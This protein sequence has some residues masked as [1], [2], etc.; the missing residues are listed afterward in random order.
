MEQI[1][2]NERDNV[3]V[4]LEGELKGHKIALSDIKKGENVIKYG[5]PIGH[6]VEDIKAGDHVHTHNIKTNLS[7]VI[8]YT[9]EP[10]LNGVSKSEPRKFMGYRRPN[11]RVGIRNE[12]WIINTVGCVNK[13]SEILA[14]EGNRLY[15]N[16]CDGIFNFVHPFGCSQLGDDQKT[17]QLILKG[18]VEHPNAAGVLVLGLGCENNNIPLFKTVLGETDEKRVKFMSAQDFDD[19]IS[20]GL[21]LIGELAE[22]AASFRRE[23]CDVSE[24]VIGLKC[25]GSDGF[26]GLTA[27][28]LIGRVSDRIIGEG[29]STVLTE[30][31]EMFGAETILMNRCVDTEVF[32]KTVSLI[33]DFKDYFTSHDQVVYENPSPGNKKGGITTLEDKSLGCVQKSGSADVVDVLELGHGVKKQGLNLLTGPGNDIVAVTNLTASGCHM[34][35]FSTGRGTP[36]GAPVP[37]V[38]IATNSAL[39]ERKPHWIDFSA[40]EILNG[41]EL[42]E[43][44]FDYIIS[45]AN[46]ART[47]NER[48]GYREI[49]I[50]KD[51]VV[52]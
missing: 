52:L 10:Q 30:V 39:A 7:G 22:Y 24:L 14:R 48:N 21:R 1:R 37:T 20:E 29:G 19:E 31:P 27:N 5:Y 9:Y 33:N 13:T 15:G 51:G 28:P 12:I 36:V 38:K 40:G 18:L 3:A 23:E 11:G 50:F 17:T 43:E 46:G 45:V 41:K 6:A 2:I 35:L 42:T 32:E 49:S 44:L 26:S 4:M 25:G 16:K 47:N 8:E 34:I